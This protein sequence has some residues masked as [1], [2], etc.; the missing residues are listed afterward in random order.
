MTSG[1]GRDVSHTVTLKIGDAV[2]GNL[3]TLGRSIPNNGRL[4]QM[5]TSAICSGIVSAYAVEEIL[6]SG[7]S[8][9]SIYTNGEF[10]WADRKAK[11]DLSLR[12]SRGHQTWFPRRFDHYQVERLR[13]ILDSQPLNYFSSGFWFLFLRAEQQPHSPTQVPSITANS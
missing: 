13:Q 12:S 2:A 11:R 8:A 1:F 5:T 7:V 10:D 6:P 4:F 9:S 3:G